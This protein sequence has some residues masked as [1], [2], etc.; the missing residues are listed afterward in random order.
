MTESVWVIVP[1]AGSGVRAGLSYPKQFALLKGVP[2]LEITITR[3]LAMP[4]VEG[5]AVALP[6][7]KTLASL[8]LS[9]E[10]VERLGTGGRPVLALSGGATRG[11]SVRRALKFIPEQAR[12]IGV[13]DAVR[14]CFTRELFLRVFAAAVKSGAAVCGMTP[15]DTVKTRGSGNVVGK[16]LDRDSLI[17]VQTPQIFAAELLREAYRLGDSKE[18]VVFTDDCQLVEGLGHPVSLV[19]GERRN[20]KITYLEDLALVEYFLGKEDMGEPFVCTGM[21]FDVHRWGPGRKCV[22]GGV[23]IPFDKGLVGHSDADVAVHAAIDAILGA[24]GE[25]DV[26]VLFPDSDPKYEGASSLSLL[27][28]LWAKLHGKARLLHLDVTIV[29]QWPKLSPHY[30]AMRTNLSR[31]LGVDVGRVSVK[32]TTTEGLGATGRGEG[33]AAF[34][35]ATLQRRRSRHLPTL[36]RGLCRE[37]R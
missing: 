26:G 29:A 1:G 9:Y 31:A 16:T 12:W 37:E 24:L 14:P 25:G 2:V 19:E 30:D 32:A 6:D 17:N 22:L 35:V 3:L 7:R 13:H 4:E 34:A 23:T 5:V 36:C 28:E 33:V 18:E 8:S 15:T 27:E 11:E 21:G 10:D 20:V